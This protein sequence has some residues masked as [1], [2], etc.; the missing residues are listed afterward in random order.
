M[1][2]TAGAKNDYR[3]KCFCRDSAPCIIIIQGVHI[4]T[5]D[6]VT[7]IWLERYLCER[8]LKMFKY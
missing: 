2:A 3:F 5:D 1:L 8:V 4:M 7:V 6:V